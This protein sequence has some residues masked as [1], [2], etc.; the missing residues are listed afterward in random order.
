MIM[1][2]HWKKIYKILW[3]CSHLASVYQASYLV[4]DTFA[5]S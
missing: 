3:G 1:G 4:G 2:D 5:N